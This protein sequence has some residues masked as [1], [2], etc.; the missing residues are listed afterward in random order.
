M[1]YDITSSNEDDPTF[2]EHRHLGP[3]KKQPTSF[4]TGKVRI[5]KPADPKLIKKYRAAQRAIGDKR[6]AAGLE[7]NQ[8]R[9][10]RK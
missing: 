10:K 8:E 4:R 5:L 3:P 2:V 7:R 9:M 1:T 6:V